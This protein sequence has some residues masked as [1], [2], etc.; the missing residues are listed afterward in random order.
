M[1]RVIPRV[2]LQAH[3]LFVLG[4]ASSVPLS[5]RAEETARS[6]QG[7]VDSIGVCTHWS[8][9]DT[10]YGFAY[11][12][13]K[14]ALAASGIRHIRDGFHAHIRDLAQIGVTTTVVAE[15]DAGSPAEWRDRI[16]AANSGG[17]AV[18]AIEGPNEPDLF[19]ADGKKRYRGETFPAGLLSFQRDLYQALKGDSA[20]AKVTV[21]GPALGKTYDPGGGS[22]NPLAPGSLANSV[23]LG[24]FHPYPGGNPFSLPFAYGTI[25]K[26]YW[27]ASIPSGNLDEFPYAFNTY[28]PPFAPKPMA[29]TETGY[30]TFRD[31]QTEE[32]QAKYVP[33]LFAEY[34]RLGV[35]KTFLYEFVDEF[36]DAA[37][38]NREAHFGLLRRDLMPKPAYT[39]VKNMIALL[40]D[41]GAAAEFRPATLDLRIEPRPVGEYD[42]T[43]FVHHLLLQKRD[44]DFYLLLWHEISNEDTSARPHRQIAPPPI[45]TTLSFGGAIRSV[46]AYLPNSSVEPVKEWVR[47]STFTINVPDRLVILK[48]SVGR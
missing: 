46:T 1:N 29:A 18:D 45:P 21:I 5:A 44:G 37:G 28:R 17:L 25:Q 12:K 6:A 48:I 38:G 20:T 2:R 39:A 16:R 32:I 9:P 8:Y 42:R 14:Q 36:E 4:L 26:Y 30:S 47:Q 13:V 7:F 23:D 19:W 41:R 22:P 24:N 15:P 31:G 27:F 40:A 33:R 34:Y 35:R 10:P 3:A 43:Q 11:E